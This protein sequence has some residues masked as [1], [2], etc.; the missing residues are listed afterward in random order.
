MTVKFEVAEDGRLQ[1]GSVIYRDHDFSFDVEP[2]PIR[3]FSSFLVND[4]SLEVDEEG[5]LLSVWG[6]CPH[7]R[8]QQ[9]I[10]QPPKATTGAIRIRANSPLSRGISTS[11]TGESRWPIVY[12]SES[13]WLAIGDPQDAEVFVSF[14][15]GA[16]LGINGGNDLKSLW[17]RVRKGLDPHC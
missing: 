4:L 1:N 11:L 14:V 7:P 16:V 13:G 17:L 3:G 6:L 10:V 8:W 15:D 5:N 2:A 9:G 12:D